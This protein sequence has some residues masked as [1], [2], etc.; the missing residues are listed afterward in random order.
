MSQNLWLFAH[1]AE[2]GAVKLIGV[3][4]RLICLGLLLRNPQYQSL[5]IFYAGQIL[6]LATRMW[7]MTHTIPVN[8]KL[9]GCRTSGSRFKA[10]LQNLLFSEIPWRTSFPSSPPS[11]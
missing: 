9:V 2:S 10:A 3:H 6:E 4:S 11:A 7:A 8:W 1:I 5:S